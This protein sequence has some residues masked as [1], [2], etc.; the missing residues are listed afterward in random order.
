MIQLKYFLRPI[1]KHI[2]KETLY[3]YVKKLVPCILPLAVMLRKACGPVGNR[4][5]P[6]ANY[7]HLGIPCEMNK[8]LSILDTFDMYSPQFDKPQTLCQIENWLKRAGLQNI[9]VWY[10]QNGI[11]GKGI[12]S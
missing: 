7:S 12:K 1:L 10:G 11:V 8:E 5:F 9:D 2:K 4:I 6:I 3:H